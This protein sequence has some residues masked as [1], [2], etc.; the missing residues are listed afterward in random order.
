M[1]P[2]WILQNRHLALVTRCPPGPQKGLQSPVTAK[3]DLGLAPPG[4]DTLTALSDLG[5]AGGEPMDRGSLLSARPGGCV[6]Q[7]IGPVV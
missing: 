1:L 7:G 2:R 5:R 4:P 6:L 3:V